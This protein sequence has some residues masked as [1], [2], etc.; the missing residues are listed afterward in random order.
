V[1]EGVRVGGADR[2]AGRA[3]GQWRKSTYSDA[4]GGDCVETASREGVVLVRDTANRE[5]TVL[6]FSSEARASF[7]D[8]LR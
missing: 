2:E 4:N 5:D 6:G 1:P 8:A 7:T 3:M